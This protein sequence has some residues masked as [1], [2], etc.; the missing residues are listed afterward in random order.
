MAKADYQSSWQ[1]WQ[2]M[3]V[4]LE[5]RRQQLLQKSQLER[6][7]GKPPT[8]EALDF[9]ES[10]LAGTEPEIEKD[11]TNGAA[12]LQDAARRLKVQAEA[13]RQ[14]RAPREVPVQKLPPVEVKQK[15]VG[16][17][18]AEDA[19]K[20]LQRARERDARQCEHRRRMQE[21]EAAAELERQ[22]LLA[23]I[24]KEQAEAAARRCAQEAWFDKLAQDIKQKKAAAEHDAW[25]KAE[26]REGA[27]WRTRWWRYMPKSE[28]AE[29]DSQRDERH[30]R[31]EWQ[32]DP[33]DAPPGRHRPGAQEPKPP[34]VDH[35][36]PE[37]SSILRELSS[38][39]HEPL[40]SRKRVWR[41]LCLRWHPDKSKESADIATRVFQQL[42]E[43]KPWF[44]PEA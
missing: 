8:R 12:Q 26:A 25:E 17:S 21:L 22:E 20:E 16:R 31:S 18:E 34:K 3:P 14:L 29:P 5:K 36:T 7:A 42:S 1:R 33:G 30:A 19:E 43:L 41:A 9:F 28:R 4:F 44:L 32:R 13:V 24:Q 37:T 11:T 2:S 39:R 6:P 10:L 38:Q 23:H 15:D 27:S 40:E 35:P